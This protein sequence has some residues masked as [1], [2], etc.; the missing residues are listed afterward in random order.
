MYEIAQIIYRKASKADGFEQWTTERMQ[1]I[2]FVVIAYRYALAFLL[3][4]AL[5]AFA[6]IFFINAQS[7]YASK[8]IL[9]A[10]IITLV[11]L[12]RIISKK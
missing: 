5:V 4:V 6:S 2:K 1:R 7:I 11:L 8:L 3:A 10:A 12:N 9:A